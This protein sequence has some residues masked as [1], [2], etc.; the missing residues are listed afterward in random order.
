[1]S[2]ATFT[3]TDIAFGYFGIFDFVSST[4]YRCFESDSSTWTGYITGTDCVLSAQAGG[5]DPFFVSIDNGAFTQ[6][7]LFGGSMPVFG[8]LADT[9]HLVKIISNGAYAPTNC[10]I[11]TTG[12]VFTVTGS[13]PAIGK[14]TD[15]GTSWAF[16]DPS[17]PGLSSYMVQTVAGEFGLGDANYN[18]STLA[19]RHPNYGS[20][21]NQVK[22]KSRCTDIWLYTGDTIAYYSID[23]G[24]FVT[25]T[26]LE[27]TD[28][29]KK[30]WRKIATGLDS[31]ASH[32]YM[33][34]SGDSQN[35][36]PQGIMIGGSSA[37]FQAYSGKLLAQLGDSITQGIGV[38]CNIDVDV[39]LYCLPF[40]T[41]VGGAYGIAGRTTAQLAADIPQILSNLP[42]LPDTV[43]LAIGRNDN[44]GSQF[45]TSYASCV[46]QLLTAGVNQVLC[47]EPTPND[48][49]V[50][51]DI[52]TVLTSINN[53][54]AILID[55]SGW[56][57][58]TTT[59][60]THPDKPGYVT[61]AN[62]EKIAYAP[63]LNSIPALVPGTASATA[64]INTVALTLTGTSGGTTPYSY[65]WYRST[66]TG[67][68]GSALSGKTTV[69]VTD[70]S[71]TAGTTYYYECVVTD[72]E[73]T[74]ALATSNQVSATPS[75][76][77]QTYPTVEQI[78]TAVQT[79]MA[80]SPVGW[81]T[82]NI[83]GNVNGSVASLTA[84]VTLNMTQAVPNTNT[85]GT[86]GDSLN[87]ARADGFGKVVYDPVGKTL[88]LYASDNTTVVKA[89]NVST[90]SNGNVLGRS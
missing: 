67:Q 16:T 27:H 78:A 4:G 68:Q 43:V 59:D 46:N 72:S 35:G 24:A 70:T 37:T 36:T 22:F 74:P 83:G 42:R 34:T 1:M 62:Y 90:D 23:G 10:K 73:G 51:S 47:R 20:G 32:L 64:G 79:I 54:K 31:S 14:G 7:T 15:L 21:S 76:P 33:V 40:D 41:Y 56:T 9:P 57:G 75:A 71:G 86:I 6:P 52:Q 17:F 39:Y 77:I 19:T 11:P 65:Q 2:T 66:T 69:N 87:A 63:Y 5:G 55:T 88:T 81:V 13:S 50:N 82:G 25:S 48:T 58:I 45:Q 60:G 12:T 38:T 3:E 44:P 84:P 61:M 53:P 30:R 89:F 8:G 26:T 49:S 85:P 28:D 18:P 80:T 29:T